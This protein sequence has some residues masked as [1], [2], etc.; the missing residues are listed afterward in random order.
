MP[1][2]GVENS[3]DDTISDFSAP[4]YEE[5][6]E[7]AVE[8]RLSVVSVSVEIRSQSP[9]EGRDESSAVLGRDLD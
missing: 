7:G 1:Q 6:P 9:D 5:S 2:M 8:G 4:M 3:G